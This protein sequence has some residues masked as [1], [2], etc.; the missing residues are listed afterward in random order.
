MQKAQ[1]AKTAKAH[2]TRAYLLRE[3]EIKHLLLK[4]TLT[5]I[6]F[7]VVK[8][9][10]KGAQRGILERK[11]LERDIAMILLRLSSEPESQTKTEPETEK[12]RALRT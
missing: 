4:N 9:D 5:T 2:E 10:I 11:R 6:V 12:K 1:K 7:L 3:L 8:N